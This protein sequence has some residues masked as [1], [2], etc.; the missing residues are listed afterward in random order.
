MEKC[1]DRPLG[2]AEVDRDCHAEFTL[3]G[4]RF[5]AALRMTAAKDSLRMTKRE[6]L[7]ITRDVITRSAS[8]VVISVVDG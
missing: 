1:R 3:S 2:L 7:A 8:D 5:F 6:G 4:T